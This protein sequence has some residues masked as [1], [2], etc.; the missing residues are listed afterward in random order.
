MVTLRPATIED[1]PAVAAIWEAGWRDGHLGNVP[2]ALVA[3]R[4]TA[5]FQ[6]RASQ[7][8]ADTTVAV[9]DDRV[10]GFTMVAGDEVEQ[11]YVDAAQRGRGVAA[12]LL[13]DAARRVHDAGHARAWLAVVPG[14]ARARA[15]YERE[16]WVDAGRF[17]H[18]AP[19]DDG[20]IPTPCHRYE[21]DVSPGRGG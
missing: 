20:P 8:T 16:G 9:V 18:A 17:D 14:N 2:D 1:A 4:T 12:V 11:V 5:S 15:F 7:R 21:K 13:A 19:T 6:A 3:A 10:V